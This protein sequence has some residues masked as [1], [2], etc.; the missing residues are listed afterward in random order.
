M[1]TDLG[2]PVVAWFIA[3]IVFWAL[4][5]IAVFSGAIRSR[6]IAVLLVLWFIGYAGLPRFGDIGAFL[7]TPWVAILDIALVFTVFKGDVRLI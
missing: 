3:Q 2:A 6:A 5:L 1:L 7:S 4:L